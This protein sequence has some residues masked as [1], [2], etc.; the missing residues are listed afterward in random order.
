MAA[1][2]VRKC[3]RGAALLWILAASYAKLNVAQ[4]LLQPTESLHDE[5]ARS[6]H[7]SIGVRALV[8]SVAC[9]KSRNGNSDQHS[10]S[11]GIPVTLCE[12][13]NIVSL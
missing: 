9:G 5:S 1:G 10:V 12:L 11:L 4:Q 13:A 6:E 2:C 8:A 7:C 3:S